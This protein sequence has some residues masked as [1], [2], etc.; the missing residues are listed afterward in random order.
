MIQLEQSILYIYNNPAKCISINNI[1]EC[2]GSGPAQLPLLADTYYGKI[3]K[4]ARLF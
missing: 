4:K 3:F 2:C 1:G